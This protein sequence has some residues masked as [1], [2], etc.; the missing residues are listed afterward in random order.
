MTLTFSKYIPEMFTMILFFMACTKSGSSPEVNYTALKVL[1]FKTNTPIA[2]ADVVLEKCTH[3]DPFGCF[4]SSVVGRIS[5]DKNGNF[6]FESKLG[7]YLIAASHVNY[8]SDHSGGNSSGPGDVY[9]TP[10]A[11]TKIRLKKLN[12]HPGDLLLRLVLNKDPTPLFTIG[13]PHSYDLPVDTAVLMESYGNYNNNIA[14]Y[15]TDRSGTVASGEGSG[16]VPNYYIN[17]F[18]TATAEVDY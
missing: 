5:T 10:V 8:W 16:M 2:D 6:K 18:D 17:R 3:P 4:E 13:I 14:W 7:V 15:F 9:L 1:E 11:Y 12:A